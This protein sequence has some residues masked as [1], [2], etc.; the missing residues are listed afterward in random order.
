MNAQKK[1]KTSLKT[2]SKDS[3]KTICILE[4]MTIKQFSQT[5]GLGTKDIIKTL[6]KNGF[7]L[8]VNDSVNESIA[9]VISEN[10][11]LD[12]K[13]VTYEEEARER[14]ESQTKEL[15]TRPPV[16]TIMGH[17]DHG[18]TTLLDALRKSNIVG[19]E[20]GGITQH[21]GAYR[22]FHDKR[23][24]TFIDTPG[25]EAFTQLRARGA[26]LTDIVVLVV[27]AD[28]GVMPQTRE[29]ISHAK[30]SGVPILVAINKIDK[31]EADTEK[32]KQQLSREGLLVEDW[33]GDV[34]S[35]EIS[36]K[37]KTNLNEL[38]EMILLLSE[39]IE[40][41]ANP[42]I[43]AQGAILEARLDAKK[44]PVATVIIQQGTLKQGE[45]FISGT[46]Y[47]KARALFDE[48]GKP[49]KSA[50]PSFPV[51]VLGFFDVP[52]AGDLF[53]VVPNLETAKRISQFRLSQI[54]KEERPEPEH[55]TLDQLFKQIEEGEF[56]E[57]ALIIKADVQG[58]VEVLTDILPSLSTKDVKIRIV[59]SATG[60]ITESDVLLAS[61]SNAIIICYNTKASQKILDL[62]KEENVE[63]RK[64]NV[65]YQLTKEIK[66]ALVGLLEPK[67]KEIYLGRAE[68]RRIFRVSKVG[69]VAGCFVI[70]GKITRNA[71]IKVIRNNEVVHKG[72][73]SSLKHLKENV[74]EINKDYECGI[75]LEKFKDIQEGDIIEAFTTE[76]VAPD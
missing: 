24:I 64:Y 54:E 27:A 38:F 35:V 36:A 8:G 19:R 41:K 22:L 65:I 46:T 33:G 56:K 61:A 25:H 55:L 68:I 37:E 62:A 60:N 69:L 39:M 59:H 63:I 12:I 72:K 13:F 47:G 42:N 4:N 29:A 6:S 21:I 52:S 76:L 70:D 75:G 34:V 14:A 9:K 23:S 30:A 48:N 53:Q 20:H 31:K 11:K 51:E 58:S 7:N 32:T 2:Q 73:I 16:V 10:F 45:F 17:V 18:K 50:E 66:A 71:E 44:G 43:E 49:L 26:N 57:L 40:I 3:T 67:R 1:E 74:T 28:D 5:S 15:T